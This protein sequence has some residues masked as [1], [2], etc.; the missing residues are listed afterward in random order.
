MFIW[1]GVK[2]LFG[3]GMNLTGEVFCLLE[4]YRYM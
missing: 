3:V 2:V 4:F 1:E